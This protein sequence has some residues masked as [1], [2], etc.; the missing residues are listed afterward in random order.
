MATLL[1]LADAFAER[2]HDG[3]VMAIEGFTCLIPCAASRKV[4]LAEREWS[5]GQDARAH[6]GETG[7][8]VT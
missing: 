1:S 5:S 4:I 3:D 7:G 2:V 8:M 6:S